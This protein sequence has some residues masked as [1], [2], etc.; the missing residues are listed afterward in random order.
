MTTAA[1]LL[2]T[3]AVTYLIYICHEDDA[4]YRHWTI[5]PTD[6]ENLAF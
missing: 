2:L 4:G 1:A 6:F 5:D 3:S